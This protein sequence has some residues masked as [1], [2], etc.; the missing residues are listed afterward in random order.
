MN[1]EEFSRF[2]DRL[3]RAE[4]G[5]SLALGSCPELAELSWTFTDGH[6]VTSDE[7]LSCISAMRRDAWKF[8]PPEVRQRKINEIVAQQPR[9]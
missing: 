8:G 9:G 4:N 1:K 5:L 7:V 6:V 3:Y 2:K